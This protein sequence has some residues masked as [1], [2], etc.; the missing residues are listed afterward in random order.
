MQKQD[1][2]KMDKSHFVFLKKSV[3][4]KCYKQSQKTN[5]PR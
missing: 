2:K 3:C 5:D 4:K 1:E